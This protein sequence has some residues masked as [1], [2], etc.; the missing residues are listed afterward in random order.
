MLK[1]KIFK[2][3]Y[4]IF[5]QQI[6]SIFFMVEIF[7]MFSTNNVIDVQACQGTMYIIMC[8]QCIDYFI[9]SLNFNPS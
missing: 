4:F 3:I 2:N 8:K 9:Y 7:T 6:F 1:D 5:S